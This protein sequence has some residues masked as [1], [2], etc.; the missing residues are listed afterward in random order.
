[1]RSLLHRS[2]KHVNLSHSELYSFSF[3][4]TTL[5]LHFRKPFQTYRIFIWGIFFERFAGNFKR[6]YTK[7]LQL[8]IRC[9]GRTLNFTHYTKAIRK[10]LSSKNTLNVNKFR[11]GSEYLNE[12]LTKLVHA[13]VPILRGCKN[14]A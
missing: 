13:A 6:H 2:P 14:N 5:F 7:L 8:L 3:L 9:S 10:S 4:N 1:M 11:G 12:R